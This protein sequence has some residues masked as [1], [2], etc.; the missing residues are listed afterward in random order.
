MSFTFRAVN[1]YLAVTLAALIWGTSGAFVK[2]LDL[3]PV[4][5]GF[6][7]TVI[8]AFALF[9][10]LKAKKTPLFT[11]NIKPMMIA[12]ALNALRT[13]LVLIGFLYASLGN[14]IIMLYTWPVFAALYGVLFL[15]ESFSLRK[16]LLLGMAVLGVIVIFMNHT[17]SLDNR[18]LIGMSAMLLH[19][20]FYAMTVVI[21]KKQSANYSIPETL[22]YQNLL[23][24][25]LFL[26]FVLML[27]Q[28]FETISQLG[29][30]AVYALWIGLLGFSLFFSGLSRIETFSASLITYLEIVGAIFFGIVFFGEALTWH[31]IVGG[32]LIVCSTILLRKR[33]EKPATLKDTTS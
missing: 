2:F 33:M 28:P 8:P 21:F 27:D 29:W 24:P 19:G 15:G 17:H 31:I 4:T 10:Y 16:L 25:F 20:V 7:R 1:P 26:P 6:I 30:G 12:S 5:I 23:A 3:P 13:Y 18:E 22:F 14:G 11:G 32:S 9:I